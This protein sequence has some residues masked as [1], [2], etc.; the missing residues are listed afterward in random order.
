MQKNS[1]GKRAYNAKKVNNMREGHKAN[2][3]NL[4]YVFREKWRRE[5]KRRV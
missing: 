2:N 5:I 4:G 1:S 3:F